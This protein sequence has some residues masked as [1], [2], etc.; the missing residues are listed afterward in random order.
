MTAPS[1]VKPRSGRRFGLRERLLLGLL[2]A[3]L[4]TVLVAVVGWVSFQR[5][6]SSQQ[7]I[8]RDTLPA[9]DALHEAVRANARLAALAPRLLR[10][11]SAA[12]L[13]QLRA[14]LGVDVP[15]V[16]DR[17]AA[18]RSPHVEA[19]LRERLQSTGDRLAAGLEGMS[20]AITERLRLRAARVERIDA[21]R[22]A[23]DGLDEL[24]RIHADNATAQLVATLT[25]LLQ[26]DPDL[27]AP[28]QGAPSLA[29][30]EAAR[31]RV[32]DLDIDSLERMHEL[33]LTVH[34]LGFLIGRL[35]EFDSVARL[36]AARAEFAEHLALLARRL[37]DIPDPGGREQGRQVHR[38]LGSALEDEGAFALRTRE[39]ALRAQ[40]ETLQSVVGELTT[41]LDALA[42]ELIHRGG[43]I[44]AAAGSAAERSATS[45][46]IAFGVIAAAL[47]LVTLGVTVHALRRH[48]LGR[49]RA[50]EEATLAL[51]SGRREVVIDTTGDDELASLAVA[52]ERFR[53]NAIERDRLAE[54][55]RGQQQDL[56][57]QVLARTAQLREANAALARETADHARARHAAEQ[58]DRAKTAFL[59]T[60]S[61]ELR[62]PLAGILGLLELVEDAGSAAERTQ[63]QAQMRA[64]A[65]LLLELLEDMLDFA[66]IEAGGV[67]LDNMGF[68][69]RDTVN[70]VFAVQGTRAAVRGLALVAEVDPALPDAVQGD[71][72]KLSQI[73]LNLVGN[74]IKFSDE[75]AVTVRVRPGSQP[76]RLHFAVEDHGIGIEPARQQE[77]F[78]PFVQVRDSGRHH[79][80]TGLG[81]A[82]CRRLVEA[83]G[84]AIELK[85][86]PGQGTTVS[87]EIALP[88]TTTAPAEA[89][90]ATAEPDA[91]AP[92][93][94]HR[95]L[96]VEDDE[97]NRMVVER[98]LDALG[99]QAV[100][101]P[102][103]HNALRLLQ[104]R[105]IDL[106]L[107]DMNLPDGDG[108]ELLARL[109]ALP[110]H[111][112]T[113]AVLMSAHIPRREVDALLEAGFAAFL[114]KPFSRQRLRTLLAELLAGGRTEP[115]A[116]ERD[117][118]ATS[119]AS[120]AEA[121]TAATAATAPEA[122]QA[123]DWIDI[124]FL[125]AEQEA[126]GE[127]IVA[128]IVRVF[129]TQGQPLIDALLAAARA[130]EHAECARLAHKLR[131][132][133]G[134]VG[135]GRLAVC[136]GALEDALKRDPSRAAGLE[137][138]AER[139]GE[140]GEAWTRTLQ[141]LDAPR[142]AAEA[143][144]A[145]EPA[146]PAPDSTSTASR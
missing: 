89:T 138:L 92:A 79:A 127:E 120:A 71:R 110:A 116:G 112:H 2:V 10:A 3:A 25:T 28:G 94:G 124:D 106:A 117:A 80:G 111:A 101:A 141:A 50:L 35:D 98:F 31:E 29:E 18:L 34:A 96:V 90:A 62:T 21:L 20:A 119:T 51:A 123:E 83:M 85:S 5:V 143:A 113:P 56:E 107:I 103:I 44:L 128:D 36:Q 58:A 102:D 12:E 121:V 108:R 73:L 84:G 118:G 134:N 26:P 133:A 70:D 76:G 14:A 68:S 81:L 15:L 129:R 22:A 8:V 104:E 46:L 126:L 86:A 130:G 52:L 97:V 135:A 33:N 146:Q 57:N 67:Q 30:R 100:C 47:L 43:R 27:G 109:R 23:I 49:L 39:L 42:G 61:H 74:A 114:S 40:V 136:A 13:G 9:A 137:D 75:G 88:A 93:P 99:Q 45:G 131:G 1:Y 78:E 132:A 145:A 53:A 77:V 142:L 144:A 32:L 7:E 54:A 69:L 105:P 82:V 11:D 87:F 19:A 65:V 48:T 95:V 59:G 66:R 115:P 72:R 24:A 38:L 64:A 41:E 6:V 16:R 122:P 125:R 139:A 140:L 17:L 63:Y 4:G 91:S 60:V 37:A 55:L